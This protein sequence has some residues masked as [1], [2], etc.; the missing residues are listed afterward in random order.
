[1]TKPRDKAEQLEADIKRLSQAC[2][3]DNWTQLINEVD[4]P[5]D[6]APALLSGRPELIKIIPPR[7]ITANEAKALF[8]II[9][10]LIE[11]NS[12]LQEHAAQLSLFV[13]NWADAFKH[14]RSLGDK[15]QRF[16]QFDHN[17]QDD[18]DEE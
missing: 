11:T 2:K 5:Y 9:G 18:E 14:L 3:L 7:D 1:M 4:V 10:S 8:N 16:A 17:M 15:I 12:A 13:G 6:I